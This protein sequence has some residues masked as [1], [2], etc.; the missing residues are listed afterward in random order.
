[1]YAV[2]RIRAHHERVAGGQV[3]LRLGIIM[4]NRM[5]RIA[6]VEHASEQ[7]FW[8]IDCL[9]P[10]DRLVP[11]VRRFNAYAENETGFAR[12]RELPS[13]LATL[14]FNLGQEL[15]VEHPVGTRTAYPAGTAFFA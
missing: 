14:V 9:A 1:M 11:F 8:R 2:S 10:A 13:G 5:P 3:W 6:V 7:S 15:R 4:E 12:R